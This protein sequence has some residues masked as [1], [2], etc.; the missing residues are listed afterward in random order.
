M[1]GDYYHHKY[2]FIFLNIIII[3]NNKILNIL[4]LHAK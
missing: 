2:H 1:Y 4:K 3:F